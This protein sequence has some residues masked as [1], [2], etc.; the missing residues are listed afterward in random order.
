ML[1]CIRL[2]FE[3]VNVSSAEL[4]SKLNQ[5]RFA[6]CCLFMTIPIIESVKDFKDFSANYLQFKIGYF[7]KNT[8]NAC[9]YQLC[10]C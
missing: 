4:K 2:S 6:C 10:N 1:S 5:L 7:H 9:N 8:K 3:M